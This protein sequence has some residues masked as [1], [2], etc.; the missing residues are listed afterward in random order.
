MQSNRLFS[1]IVIVCAA[2]AMVLLMRMIKLEAEEYNQ[3]AECIS[4]YIK[5]GVPR[6]QI[7][8]TGSTCTLKIR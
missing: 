6:D 2:I 5:Q 4:N 7:K 8:R 1:V 3:S